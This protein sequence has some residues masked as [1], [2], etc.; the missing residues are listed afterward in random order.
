MEI[1]LR[2]PHTK[3]GRSFLKPTSLRSKQKSVSIRKIRDIRVPF[4]Y[5]FKRENCKVRCSQPPPRTQNRDLNTALIFGAFY[6]KRV[7][8][9]LANFNGSTLEWKHP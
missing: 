7:H 8:I 5:V 1:F 3:R 6:F 2:P 4:L 9:S